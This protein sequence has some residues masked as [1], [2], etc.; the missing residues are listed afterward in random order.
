[1][2]VPIKQCFRVR[3]SYLE[4]LGL[5]GVPLG[6]QSAQQAAEVPADAP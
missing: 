4:L 2:S 6:P 1:M 5:A 3:V